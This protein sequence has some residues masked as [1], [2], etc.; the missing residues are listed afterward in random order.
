[1]PVTEI[2]RPAPQRA[3]Q[4]WPSALAVMVVGV[5]VL[6]LPKDFQILGDLSFLYPVF[7]AVFLVI[8]VVGIR[9]G[10]TGSAGGCGSPPG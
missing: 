4:R 2:S 1:M 8:L 9:A 6:L 5:A 3:E 10:S 7:L